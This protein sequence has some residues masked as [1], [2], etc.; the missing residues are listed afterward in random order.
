MTAKTKPVTSTSFAAIAAGNEGGF[1]MIP[2]GP[3]PASAIKMSVGSNN[4]PLKH[5]AP[6]S[7][8]QNKKKEDLSNLVPP[9]MPVATV[10]NG[11]MEGKDYSPFKTFKVPGA[12]G[13][14]GS[15]QKMDQHQGGFKG[16]AAPS[17][18]SSNLDDQLAKAPGYRQSGGS[19]NSSLASWN[20]APPMV[21]SGLQ[22]IVG[23][24]SSIHL[25]PP[26]SSAPGYKKTVTQTVTSVTQQ[27]GV[28][29][30]SG[31]LY[32]TQERC[33]SAPGT[34]VSPLVPAPIG[35]PCG[36]N[37]VNST[38]PGDRVVKN[39]G[40]PGSEPE[41]FRGPSGLGNTLRS[42]TPDGD[43]DRGWGG[44]LR[45][46]ELE[47]SRRHGTG[48]YGH[49]SPAKAPGAPIPDLFGRTG[50]AVHS[51]VD[52]TTGL[53]TESLLSAAT[54]LSNLS[55]NNYDMMV[56]TTTPPSIP[57]PSASLAPGIPL[58]EQAQP[59]QM[60]GPPGCPPSI[61]S[62]F[63]RFGLGAGG[64]RFTAPTQA[65]TAIFSQPPAMSVQSSQMPK[66]LNPNAPDFNRGGLYN[67]FRG[68]APHR[69]QPGPI[70]P[71]PPKAGNAFGYNIG[72]GVIG[73]NFGQVGQGVGNNFQN[74]L[75]NQGINAYLSTL[76]LGGNN[77]N[78]PPIGHGDHMRDPMSG[79][80]GLA[81]LNLGGRTLSE[82]T[83]MLGPDAV[84]GYNPV[85]NIN[86]ME[87]KFSSRPIGA[88]RQRTGP[89]PIGQLGHSIAPGG[90]LGPVQSRKVDPFGVWDLPPSYS[91]NL[92]TAN[93]T[94]DS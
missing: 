2:T 94:N 90:G 39:N 31:Q 19:P 88:E 47:S 60:P 3:P 65:T 51:K 8:G 62:S 15:E 78:P 34:P 67:S 59:P 43:L 13:N 71:Q 75:T 11:S 63:N 1:G 61:P 33:N 45:N 24:P 23:P 79:L 50:N 87:P 83:D 89:S 20:T 55:V 91:D 9:L 28:S 81:D 26:A 35:P 69:L 56:T 85:N 16:F 86:E 72:A 36:S 30:S 49:N 64:P 70:P 27:V 4:L 73:N 41:W 58:P 57:L 80:A 76:N 92:S 6:P 18:S 68:A 52:P 42:M 84:L 22:P 17:S 7:S 29:E 66:G 93:L 14:W 46:D 82:I 54:Q 10:G 44:P 77:L 12:F 5:N 53:A 74:I 37:H 21:S 38:G 48:S 25:P 40:S 32:S